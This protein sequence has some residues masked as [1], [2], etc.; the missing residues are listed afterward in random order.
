MGWQF[1]ALGLMVLGGCFCFM[2][3]GAKRCLMVWGCCFCFMPDG[4]RHLFIAL[5]LELPLY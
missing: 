2:P 5:Y 4:A 1:F 3:D